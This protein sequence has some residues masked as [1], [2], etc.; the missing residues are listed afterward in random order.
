MI[1]TGTKTG[2]GTGGGDWASVVSAAN[3]SDS[4]VFGSCGP[5]PTTAIAGGGGTGAVT[6]AT[7]VVGRG[8]SFG[9][10]L[11]ISANR[12]LSLRP[13]RCSFM[14]SA[15]DNVNSVWS[16]SMTAT[17]TCSET[18]L[19]ESAT[20]SSIVIA[21]AVAGT[22]PRRTSINRNKRMS[23]SVQPLRQ[24]RHADLLAFLRVRLHSAQDTFTGDGHWPS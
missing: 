13:S 6:G 10:P 23:K 11:L 1:G 18:P 8:G 5:C 9:R 17:M 16:R 15:G 24:S 21:D 20:T 2:G 4:D 14:I 19:L 12:I 22:Q 7:G 3:Q